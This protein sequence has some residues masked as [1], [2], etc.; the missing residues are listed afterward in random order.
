MAGQNVSGGQ[1][2]RLSVILVTIMALS[3]P[4]E[5]VRAQ[6]APTWHT[7]NTFPGAGPGFPIHALLEWDDGTG[8]ALYVAGDFKFI[9]NQRA[10]SIAKWNGR[11][12]SGLAGGVG[13]HSFSN[14]VYSI[15]AYRNK[16]IASGNFRDSDD[17]ALRFV[18]A[19]DGQRWS[20]V[21]KIGVF[22]DS[23]TL[24]LGVI[25][26]RLYASGSFVEQG[27]THRL[28]TWNGV[29]W[30]FVNPGP[31]GAVYALTQFEGQPVIGGAFTEVGKA[32]C[33]KVARFD[34]Q[35]WQPMGSGFSGDVRSLAVFD[36]RLYAC[37]SLSLAGNGSHD[38]VA[39][40]SGRSWEIIASS[41]PGSFV[42]AYGLR[43][44]RGHLHVYGNFTNLNGLGIDHVARWDGSA[45]SAISSVP[46][47]NRVISSLIAFNGRLISARS[48]NVPTL[49]GVATNLTELVDGEWKPVLTGLRE[50][51]ANL[52]S[53]KGRLFGVFKQVPV[54]GGPTYYRLAEHLDGQW[55]S[56]SDQLFDGPINAIEIDEE[57][58]YVGG[59]FKHIDTK[60]AANL[61]RWDGANWTDVG[62]GLCH[63]TATTDTVNALAVFGDRLVAGG[64]FSGSSQRRMSLIAQW[65][66]RAW[67]ALDEGLQAGTGSGRVNALL[68]HRG[69]L[70]VGGRFTYSTNARINNVAAWDGAQWTAMAEGTQPTVNCL[71]EYQGE[72]VAGLQ[73]AAQEPSSVL[74]WTGSQW[75][76]FG[77]NRANGPVLSMSSTAGR[78]MIRTSS[79]SYV[80]QADRNGPGDVETRGLAVSTGAG[81]QPLGAQLFDMSLD[82]TFS[83]TQL[84][85][86]Q[87]C[88]WVGGNF[89]SA[90][91]LIT[92]FL[93]KWGPP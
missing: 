76:M 79:T 67:E 24:L 72:V 44:I 8:P 46:Q 10:R 54:P 41:G 25:D 35:H 89:I 63:P 87:E 13:N 68:A 5:A 62:A 3:A 6:G 1:T 74:R 11:E 61:A 92:P 26:D 27:V 9:G 50:P 32:A 33:A 21:G 14:H 65:D 81:W 18:A 34:G 42:N 28:A 30:T 19:W 59:K 38:L 4:V 73:G 51:P 48:S 93:A 60:P 88:F 2:R 20:P 53:R 78:L 57:A 70:I 86:D 85:A 45:W 43:V 40:W 31:N 80:S 84:A 66:G 7:G 91:G 16:L 71:A 55:M 82:V 58:L 39:V 37:G 52:L 69:Q 75:D 15:T 64:I 90:G 29:E 47:D 77:I 83:V 23:S 49:S 36:G 22:G 17:P 56:V 12:W